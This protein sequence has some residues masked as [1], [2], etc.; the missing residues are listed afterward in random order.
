M[1]KMFVVRNDCFFLRRKYENLKKL[2][3][4]MYIKKSGI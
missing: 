2:F 3:C 1:G 4:E